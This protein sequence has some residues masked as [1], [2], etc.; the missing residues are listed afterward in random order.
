MS[1]ED[2][3]LRVAEAKPKD[4]GRG[5]ARIDPAVVNILGLTTG[6]VIVIEEKQ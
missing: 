4:V 1:D 5:I 3:I 2:K 6:D